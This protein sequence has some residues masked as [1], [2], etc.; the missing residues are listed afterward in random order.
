MVGLPQFNISN[1]HEVSTLFIKLGITDFYQAVSYV[2]NIPYGRNSNKTKYTQVLE[3]NIGTCSTK[4][5]LLSKLC[6]EQGILDIHLMI[7][8]YE[9]NEKNTPGTGRILDNYNLECLPE[10]HCYLKYKG[11]MFDYTRTDI[12]AEPIHT[13]LY[14][15]IIGPDQI[16]DYKTRIHKRFINEWIKNNRHGIM[17]NSDTI[18]SIR[19]ECIRALSG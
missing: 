17:Y 1:K 5:A 12:E 16:G 15:T 11:M 7:G 6:I 19:E 3:E 9:M 13:F 10:A 18:W 8:I 14:E 2:G 4:H